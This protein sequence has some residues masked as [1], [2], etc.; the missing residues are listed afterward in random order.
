MSGH[1]PSN[2][3][4]LFLFVLVVLLCVLGVFKAV[5]Q[6]DARLQW[7]N[8]VDTTLRNLQTSNDVLSQTVVRDEQA[9]LQFVT[10]D[11]LKNAIS[12][13]PT[14]T[15]KPENNPIAGCYGIVPNDTRWFNLTCDKQFGWN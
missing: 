15:P 7:M 4:W 3:W 1:Y 14:V 13:T 9:H 6:R 2:S 10:K 11:E 8:G 12:S 5:E